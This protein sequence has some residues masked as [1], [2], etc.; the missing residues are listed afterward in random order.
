[1]RHASCSRWCTTAERPRVFQRPQLSR[2]RSCAFGTQRSNSDALHIW[3]KGMKPQPASHALQVISNAPNFA[4]SRTWAR[5]EENLRKAVT[6]G[7]DGMSRANGSYLQHGGRGPRDGVAA[8]CCQQCNVTETELEA[9]PSGSF[10]CR[11]LR[12]GSPIRKGSDSRPFCAKSR[13]VPSSRTTLSSPT[14][15]LAAPLCTCLIY[16]RAP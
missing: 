5:L 11:P 16:S 3:P 8:N 2:P 13:I 12:C 6:S 10:E 4:A 1:M 14:A 9:S 7:A 15:P